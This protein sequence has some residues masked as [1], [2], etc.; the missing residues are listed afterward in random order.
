MIAFSGFVVTISGNMI[1]CLIWNKKLKLK[2]GRQ[3]VQFELRAFSNPIHQCTTQSLNVTQCAPQNHFQTPLLIQI[4]D[5][6][7]NEDRNIVSS[8]DS[9]R[10]KRNTAFSGSYKE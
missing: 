8:N 10:P 4:E 7:K 5:E 9:Q 2:L 6:A 3:N 1:V